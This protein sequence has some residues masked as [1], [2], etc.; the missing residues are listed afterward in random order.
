MTETEVLFERARSGDNDALAEL[1]NPLRPRLLALIHVRMP[2]SARHEV[3]PEDILQETIVRAIE[4]LP[5]FDWNGEQRFGSWLA[6]IA[7]NLA[8]SAQRDARCDRRV[9]EP[10]ETSP[11]LAHASTDGPQPLRAL[12][13]EE[14]FRRL[15]R[16]LDEIP[17]HYREV[18][19][20]ARLEGLGIAE[21]GDRI[22]KSPNATSMLLL[23]A[24]KSL[25]E[26][27]GETESLRLPDWSL[28]D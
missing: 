24:L 12:R 18:I 25:R 15:E 8:R 4:A 7:T 10:G 3:D 28:P 26:A 5:R 6:R 9:G 11:D 19:V 17:E 22:G 23:R 2:R 16:A 1:V 20:L 21:I 13:R 27:F 14:R